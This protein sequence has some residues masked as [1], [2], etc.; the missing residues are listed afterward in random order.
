MSENLRPDVDSNSAEFEAGVEAGLNSTT[1]DTNWQAGKTLGQ[2]LKRES[3]NEVP[4]VEDPLPELSEPSIPLFLQSSRA[5]NQE[6][7]QDEKD[8]TEE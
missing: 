8:E 1:E 6:D 4:V 3:V 7:A 2:E 5:G